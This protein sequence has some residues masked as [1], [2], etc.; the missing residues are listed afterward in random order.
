VG[1]HKKVNHSADRRW[2]IRAALLLVFALVA[3]ACGGGGSGGSENGG[4][5][6]DEDAG[7]PQSGGKVVYALEAETTGGW[8]LPE[9]QLAIAG[10]QV[11]RS[12]YDTLTVPNDEGK[13]EPFLA[14]AV[15]PNDTYTEWTIELREGVKFHDGSD[16]TAEVVKNNIDAYRGQYPGRNSLLF[17]FVLQDIQDV[18][19]DGPLTVKVTTKRPWVSFDSFLYSSG[20]FGMVAQ[21]QLDSTT[22]CDRDLIGT[23][24][25]KLVDW[26]VNSSMKLSR[27]EDYWREDEN[28]NKLPYLDELE[29]RPITEAIQMQN[30]LSAGNIDAFHVSSNT[31]A[32]ILQDM[33]SEAD[34][35]NINLTESDDFAEVGFLMLNVTKPPFDNLTAREAM[36]VAVDRDATNETLNAGIPELANGPFA[37]GALG[38][39]EDSGYPDY[40][41]AKAKELV[42]QYKEETGK[43]LE[44][45][46]S[47]VQDTALLQ[48][49][50][51]T[52]QYL[53]DAG[54]KVTITTLEQSA[55]INTAIEKNYQ[56][57]TWRN[58]PGFDPDNLY[59]WWYGNDNPVNFMGFDDPEVNELLDQGRE[60]GDE[61][62]RKQ[63]Y[64]D[65]NRELNKEKYQIWASWT[66]WAVPTATDV[67]GIVG[68]RPIGGDGSTDYTGLAV[69]NDPALM[70]REQ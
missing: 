25:F 67:H 17:L 61:A 36:A 11:A 34:S 46:I 31:N 56:A 64:E 12:I 51:L 7:P 20:R 50:E 68:A 28:G 58:Y 66:I 38:Y 49:V 55:L 18:T 24:P 47:A 16:L 54:M 41:P 13:F 62:E 42:D 53:E 21:K 37:K 9:A 19:V 48:S 63:I 33:R 57:I 69:G 30:G 1:R 29:Y 23:G 4:S 60:T 22:A 52:K 27:N 65:L 59:V 40:D 44:V 45:Q 14:K 8:C 15:T 2:T 26:Q 43:D 3:A 35:G 6:G 5:N 10:I 39:L 32:L 70:W